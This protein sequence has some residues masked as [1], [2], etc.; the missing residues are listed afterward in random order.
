MPDPDFVIQSEDEEKLKQLRTSLLAEDGAAPKDRSASLAAD[1]GLA[2]ETTKPAAGFTVQA[3]QLAKREMQ[4][5]WRNKPAFIAT[6]LV[7]TVLNLFF[8]LIFFKV[9]R[10]DPQP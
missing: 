3:V 4:G 9:T 2:A 1:A 7:P 5:M 6:F 10:H 8:A